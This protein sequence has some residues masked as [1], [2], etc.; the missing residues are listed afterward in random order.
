[1]SDTGIDDLQMEIEQFKASVGEQISQMLLQ[2]AHTA[3]EGQ[4]EKIE[5][6]QNKL[7][8]AAKAF[9]EHKESV[10]AKRRSEAIALTKRFYALEE[11]IGGMKKFDSE[12]RGGRREDKRRVRLPKSSELNLATLGEER[13]NYKDFCEDFDNQLGNVW[14]GLDVLLEKARKEKNPIDATSF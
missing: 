10:E 6:L 4:E 1:M 5:E 7:E 14:I 11:V 3:I 2:N 8:S 13:S 9:R 12:G